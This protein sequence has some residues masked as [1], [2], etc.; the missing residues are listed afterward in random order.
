M[1]N[2]HCK[3]YI[4]QPKKVDDLNMFK[5]KINIILTLTFYTRT[6]AYAKPTLQN[7]KEKQTL[8]AK[9]LE[10]RKM[11]SKILESPKIYLKFLEFIMKF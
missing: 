7:L 1:Y 9:H 11:N 2:V 3:M 4:V 8:R 5:Y 6:R 10:I